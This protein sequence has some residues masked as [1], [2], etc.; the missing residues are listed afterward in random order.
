MEQSSTEYGN[1]LL[2]RSAIEKLVRVTLQKQRSQDERTNERKEIPKLR[3]GCSLP[4]M[5]ALL[6][7]LILTQTR[8]KIGVTTRKG[9]TTIVSWNAQMDGMKIVAAHFMYGWLKSR[10][11]KELWW[12]LQQQAQR[13]IARTTL[14]SLYL[15]SAQKDVL[16]DLMGIT[17]QTKGYL[18]KGYGTIKA[19]KSTE[20]IIKGIGMIG[21]LVYQLLQN[22]RNEKLMYLW[23]GLLV[24]TIP[25]NK[26]E[27]E[28]ITSNFKDISNSIPSVMRTMVK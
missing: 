9:L 7:P 13:M 6:I 20:T 22:N 25:I 24:R 1:T 4:V 10:V 15:L 18:T 19:K 2:R 11:I 28:A 8:T 5:G 26:R 16:E 21:M 17:Y 23:I 27:R 3:P 12:M 14:Y